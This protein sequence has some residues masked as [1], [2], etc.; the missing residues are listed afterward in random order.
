MLSRGNTDLTQI[1]LFWRQYKI[2][3]IVTKQHEGDPRWRESGTLEKELRR[4]DVK[5]NVTLRAQA[6]QCVRPRTGDKKIWCPRA[7]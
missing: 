5:K 7:T 4:L 1:R 3:G 2:L 6:V